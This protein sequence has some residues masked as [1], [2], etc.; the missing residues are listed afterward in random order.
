MIRLIDNIMMKYKDLSE[1]PFFCPKTDLSPLYYFF[2]S[3]LDNRIA[4]KFGLHIVQYSPS[5]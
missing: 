5:M 3:S 2:F 1:L 4:Q